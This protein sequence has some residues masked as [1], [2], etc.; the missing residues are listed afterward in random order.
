M[1]TIKKITEVAADTILEM[2]REKLLENESEKFKYEW[3]AIE[4][5]LSHPSKKLAEVAKAAREAYKNA[6]F[7]KI[8]TLNAEL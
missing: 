2:E 1:K 3:D 5:E 8:T 6:D 7:S 4:W